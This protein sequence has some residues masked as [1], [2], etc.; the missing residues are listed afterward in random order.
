MGAVEV[1]ESAVGKFKDYRDAFQ[2]LQEWD[3]YENGH[4]PYSGGIYNCDSPRLMEEHPRYKSKKFYAW[5]DD[6]LSIA[7]KKDCFCIELKGSALKRMK[8]NR[9]KG[10]RGIKAFIFF[11]I[12]PY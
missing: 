9:Y 1:N 7:C 2:Q 11:G 6:I 5:K 3:T 10:R 4:D 8:G 12:A